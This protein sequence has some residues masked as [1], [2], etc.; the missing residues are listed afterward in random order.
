MKNI[1]IYKIASLIMSG[2]ISFSLYG[3]KKEEKT[4]L[5]NMNVK[6]LNEENIYKDINM[7]IPWDIKLT[8]KNLLNKDVNVNDLSNITSLSLNISNIDNIEDLYWLNYCTNLENL[9]LEFNK[10]TNFYGIKNLSNLKKLP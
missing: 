6:S 7:D 2:M 3:C 4:I 1:K 5:I 8:L 9:T 10:K